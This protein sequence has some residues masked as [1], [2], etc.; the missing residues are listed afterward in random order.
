[1]EIVQGDIT[2]QD[3][4]AIVNAAN[5]SLL[6]A[7][8]WTAPFIE[9]PARDFWPNAGGWEAVQRDRPALRPGIVCR[10]GL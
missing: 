8:G 7:V 2:L 1:M 4:D 6:A 9:L 10:P 5:E 3:V